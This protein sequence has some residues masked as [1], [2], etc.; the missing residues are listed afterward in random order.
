M[1]EKHIQFTL[2]VLGCCGCNNNNMLHFPHFVTLQTFYYLNTK[3]KKRGQDIE[4]MQITSFVFTQHTLWW[5][6]CMEP[7]YWY[8]RCCSPLHMA[9]RSLGKWD[10]FLTTLHQRDGTKR[11]AVCWEYTDTKISFPY[12]VGS[13]IDYSQP[14]TQLT[15]QAGDGEGKVGGE[16]RSALYISFVVVSPW[17]SLSVRYDS[18]KD[19]Q[20]SSSL[21]L[22]AFCSRKNT[23]PQACTFPCPS[24]IICMIFHYKKH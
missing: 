15:S 17:F 20:Q 3:K 8:W 11:M 10:A 22:T 5:F 24:L 7:P 23:H 16:T 12:L 19:C 6:A 14:R 9:N 18:L 21:V 2:S 1:I 4:F 13:F